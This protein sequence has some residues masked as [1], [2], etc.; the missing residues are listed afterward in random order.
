M[1]APRL[2][3]RRPRGMGRLFA[4]WGSW[5]ELAPNSSLSPTNTRPAAGHADLIRWKQLSC[6]QGN[7][8][9]RTR[10]TQLLRSGPVR[11]SAGEPALQLLPSFVRAADQNHETHRTGTKAPR[12]CTPRLPPRLLTVRKSSRGGIV[13]V[14]HGFGGQGPVHVGNDTAPSG[15]RRTGLAS[16]SPDS[17]ANDFVCR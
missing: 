6:E 2:A 17:T 1:A 16:S 8:R 11:P 9:I 7:C 14:I 13:R 10:D 12:S 4:L 5:Q 15:S 3:I